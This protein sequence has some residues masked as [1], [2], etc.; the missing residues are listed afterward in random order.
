MPECSKWF[1]KQPQFIV[2]SGS[3]QIAP[4]ASSPKTYKHGPQSDSRSHTQH[5]CLPHKL[6]LLHGSPWLSFCL[7]EPG[8]YNR[9]ACSS[10]DNASKNCVKLCPEVEGKQGVSH[11]DGKHSHIST[12][13]CP[14][15]QVTSNQMPSHLLSL[16]RSMGTLNQ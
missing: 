8:F 12:T 14:T 16:I 1:N 13:H 3:F 9:P 11:H 6:I 4:E 15:V 5:L 7:Y 2:K 10:E